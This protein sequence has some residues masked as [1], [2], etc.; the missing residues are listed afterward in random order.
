MFVVK[1]QA[2]R[3]SHRVAP[4]KFVYC[5]QA[6]TVPHCQC[7]CARIFMARLAETTTRRSRAEAKPDTK[8]AFRVL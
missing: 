4:I 1:L 5:Q 8:T 6:L 7:D 3:K 2:G